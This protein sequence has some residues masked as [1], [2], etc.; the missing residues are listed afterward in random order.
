MSDNNGTAKEG[1][2][3]EK[4]ENLNKLCDFLRSNEG[5]AVRE[6][7]EERIEKRVHYIKGTWRRNVSDDVWL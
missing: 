4:D 6:A 3:W 5:P 2:Y 1:S 7:V